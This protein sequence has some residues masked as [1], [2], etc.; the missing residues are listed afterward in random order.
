MRKLV[1]CSHLPVRHREAPGVGQ[2]D[3]RGPSERGPGL[4]SRRPA[5][6]QTFLAWPE[7]AFR[8]KASDPLAAG[9]RQ[10]FPLSLPPSGKT[11][12]IPCKAGHRPTQGLVPGSSTKPSDGEAAGS[13]QG[14]R[15]GAVYCFP[16]ELPIPVSVSPRVS[17][18]SASAPAPPAQVCC[19]P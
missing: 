16:G 14:R 19:G 4:D 11:L 3:R 18:D 9:P 10:S 5:S 15:A 2:D 12:A 1:V 6:M 13:G 8:E 7:G 17:A